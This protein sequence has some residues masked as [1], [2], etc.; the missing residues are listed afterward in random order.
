MSAALKERFKRESQLR[1]LWV[2]GNLA[3]HQDLSGYFLARCTERY[4]ER[5]GKIAF[6]MPYSC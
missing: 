5:G 4:L 6:V 2:G 1:G 3:T